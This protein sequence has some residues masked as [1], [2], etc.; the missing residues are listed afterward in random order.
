MSSAAARTGTGLLSWRGDLAPGQ[1]RIGGVLHVGGINATELARVYGTPLLAIDLDVLD[2][3]IAQLEAACKPAGIEISYAGK[4]LLITT[5]ARR[6]A[7]TSVG[8]DVCS[9]GE[10]LTGER[11]DFPAERMTLHGCGKSDAELQAAI[12]RRVETIVVDNLDELTRLGRLSGAV[13]PAQVILRINTGIEAHTHDFVLTSGDRT[14]FGIATRDFGM[15]AEL[16]ARY[17]RLDFAGL[18]SH[19][20]SQIF[21][22][23]A[24]R[25]NT[26]AIIDAAAAFAKLGL[27]SR[28]LI[29][30]GGFGIETRPN[31]PSTLNIADAIAAIAQ[32]ASQFGARIGIEPG[33]A[34]IGAAGT[35]I[36]TVMARKRQG[37]R[38]FVVID[39]GIADNPRPA[40]YN[41][42]HHALPVVQEA[43]ENGRTTPMTVCGRSCE[44]DHYTDATLP[45]T[46]SAGDLLAVC[47]TGAY[48]YSMAS[49]YNRFPRPPVVFVSG[50]EHR[51]AA[52]RETLDDVLRSD[53]D[54]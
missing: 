53:L 45:D 34:L 30:G 25:A 9:L 20:G 4:A 38:E 36:Y 31:D 54:V 16:L 49:N 51:P 13:R 1:E 19:I 11:A 48:T 26:R 50:G 3:T 6:L 21:E 41:A 27:H 7:R 23:A 10:L 5:L 42:Y 15:A 35:S 12:D 18:H 33:R 44:N 29:V 43:G 52:R 46:L 37:E 24:F 17:N 40:L 47:T 39:G 28:E 8:L 14:K 32:S 22:T 2:E